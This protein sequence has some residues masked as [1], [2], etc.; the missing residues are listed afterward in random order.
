MH[1]RPTNSLAF[2]QLAGEV[3]ELPRSRPLPPAWLAVLAC[4]GLVLGVVVLLGVRG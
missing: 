3:L 1:T 4:L 2:R